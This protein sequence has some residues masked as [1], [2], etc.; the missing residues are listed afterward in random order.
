VTSVLDYLLSV[1][2]TDRGSLCTVTILVSGF[3]SAIHQPHNANANI[4]LGLLTGPH[5]AL[6]PLCRLV[7]TLLLFYELT[8]TLKQSDIIF[9]FHCHSALHA[10]A[11]TTDLIREM[12]CI[13]KKIGSST[14]KQMKTAKIFFSSPFSAFLLPFFFPSSSIPFPFPSPN[15]ARKSGERCSILFNRKS[16]YKL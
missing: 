11:H 9:V 5:N 12:P 15:P 1:S 13:P 7:P 4:C 14:R 6:S 10:L 16:E 8:L 3:A 2:I